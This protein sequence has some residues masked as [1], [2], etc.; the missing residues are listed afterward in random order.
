M[1]SVPV[2]VSA[3]WRPGFGYV[4]A[5]VSVTFPVG[6]RYEVKMVPVTPPFLG[7]PLIRIIVLWGLYWGGY[8]NLGKLPYISYVTPSKPHIGHAYRS[9]I[10]S[11]HIPKLF[12]CMRLAGHG[13]SV[14]Q[15][16]YDHQRNGSFQVV[17][18]QS[19]IPW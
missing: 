16:L 7:V 11:P 15:L 1:I 8:H 9:P 6:S 19:F 4:L 10:F 14:V 5:A 2:S 3:T 17:L 12:S 13:G 18:F